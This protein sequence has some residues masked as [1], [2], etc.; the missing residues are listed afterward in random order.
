MD[1]YTTAPYMALDFQLSSL[2]VFILNIL[3]NSSAV[4]LGHNS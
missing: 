4:S 3:C 2:A 1:I